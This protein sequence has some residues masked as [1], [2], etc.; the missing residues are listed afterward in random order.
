MKLGIVTPVL[1]LNPRAHAAWERDAT[2][3]DVVTIAR[4]A[5]RLGYHHLTCSEHVAVPAAAAPVRGATYWDPLATFG[6]LAAVTTTIRFATFVLVLGYHHPLDI[7]KRYGTLDRVT[8][9]RLILGVGVGSLREEFEVLGMPFEGRG[10]RGDDALRALRASFGVREPRYDGSHYAFGGMVV[11]PTASQARVPIWVGGQTE[12]SLRRAVELADAWTP[13]R[14]APNEVDAA[15]RRARDSEAWAARETS[16]EIGLQPVPPIDP[17]AD[18]DGSRRVVH[19]LTAAGATML[20]LRFAHR[21]LEHYCDQL[22]A[23]MELF[24][25]P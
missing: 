13:F 20:N 9:G 10:A 14:L 3:D 19:E 1:T 21:S 8:G 5:E 16:L 23:A 4:T 17:V 22:A 25:P 6:Y 15:L 2:F 12:R 24:G 7:A 18:P 11:S